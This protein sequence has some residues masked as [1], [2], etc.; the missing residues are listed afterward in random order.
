M[1]VRPG[2]QG[3]TT[4]IYGSMMRRGMNERLFTRDFM[5]D[6]FISLCCSLN[7][8]VLLI[9][10]VDFASSEFGASSAESG[11]A[12]GIYV[13]GGL[14]S[15]L[16]LGKYIELVGRRRMLLL[17]LFLALVM[18]GTY[19]L[20]DSLAM[21][22]LVRLLHGVTYGLCSTATS[23]I[24][25]KIIPASRRGEGLGYFYLS[26]TASTAIG[27]FLGLHLGAMGDYDYVFMVGVLMYAASLVLAFFLRVPE[28][29][30]DEDQKREARRFNLGNLF[31]LSAVPLAATCMVFY[32]A[33]SGVLSFISSYAESIDMVEAASYF[34]IAVSLGT[35]ISRLSTGRI[36][37]RHGPNI[38]MIPGYIAFILGMIAFSRTSDAWMFLLS[39]FIMG[40]GI[41]IIFAVCQAIVVT[42]SP[43]HR[44]GVTTSTFSAIVDLGTGFGPTVMGIVLPL[45]GFRDM[46]L[47]C[48][49][50]AV[51]SLVMYW[52]IHG[53][54]HGGSN[55]N[56]VA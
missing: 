16:L 54:R 22:Y 7:Y 37:D 26:I 39:G 50:I 52:L 38:I 6:M 19:F 17:G 5:L 23:D 28:E 35:L 40:Y 8:F 34:Y 44:Y 30:L 24:V 20:I 3:S 51:V 47:M 33:Y 31:Q 15:R 41:S 43:P 27:P 55:G 9:N 1:V 12:A 14:V 46:Y 29:V 4:R 13:L 10:M 18:S 21:L 48:A 32:L 45:L 42:R 36:Y 53:A 56:D 25:A 2:T 11:M 49:C